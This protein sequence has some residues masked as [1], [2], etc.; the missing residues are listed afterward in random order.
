MPPALANRHAG[1][2]GQDDADVNHAADLRTIQTILSHADISTTEL[3]TKVS[4]E[5]IREVLV[6][7]HPRAN[8][9]H[10]QMSLFPR[11]EPIL[12]PGAIICSQ[13]PAPALEA[14]T[15]CELHLK[16]N[17]ERS[18]RSWRKAHSKK[19]ER[20]FNKKHPHRSKGQ[21]GA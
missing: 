4:Q 2:S 5:R 11:P 16:L 18:R 21:R 17:R 14:Y 20:P 1:V 19:A 13:C 6:R 3:Y 10:T 9:K 7:C 12:V 15:Y 8:R